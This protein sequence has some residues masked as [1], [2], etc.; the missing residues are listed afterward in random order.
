MPWFTMRADLSVRAPDHIP[1]NLP[2]LVPLPALPQVEM[3]LEQQPQQL[4]A[5]GL[6][7]VLQVVVGQRGR[8]RAGQHPCQALEGPYRGGER[9]AGV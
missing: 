2:R 4:T 6:D 3:G 1:T 5:L 8:L 9:I 7:Q